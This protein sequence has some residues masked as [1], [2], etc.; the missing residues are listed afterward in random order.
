MRVFVDTNVAVDV[1]AR[2]EPFAADSA[3]I[4]A[5]AE[6]RKVE[7]FV[8]A[9]S[10][11]TIFYITRRTRSRRHA[12]AALKVLREVFAPAACDAAVIDRA[13][14]AG[15]EDFEDAVQYFSAIAC[16]AD[17]LVTRNVGHYPADIVPPMT[18]AAFL[19]A[20]SFA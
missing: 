16:G 20:H 3:R 12:D 11:T 19:A 18:P 15:F 9:V 8:S 6:T 13:L 10:F 14:G 2:R 17:V 5:L 1:L 4:W 7:G